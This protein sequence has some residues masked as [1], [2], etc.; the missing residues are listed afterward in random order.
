MGGISQ[1]QPLNGC[2]FKR[3][4]LESRWAMGKVYI[5]YEKRRILVCNWSVATK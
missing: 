2:S 4:S 3:K 1:S 5:A